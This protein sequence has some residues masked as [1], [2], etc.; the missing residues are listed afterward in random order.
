MDI[1]YISRIAIATVTPGRYRL[2]WHACIH[3]HRNTENSDSSTTPY[4]TIKE[5]A[6]K[7]KHDKATLGAK[8]VATDRLLLLEILWRGLEPLRP[9]C[10]HHLPQVLH[11]RP[12]PQDVCRRDRGVRG[13]QASA[14]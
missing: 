2:A 14:R 6:K 11:L 9:N 3:I 8:G 5:K 4:T 7:S 1:K 12:E 10:M 13:E